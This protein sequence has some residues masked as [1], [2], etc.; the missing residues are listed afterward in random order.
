MKVFRVIR[1]LIYSALRSLLSSWKLNA[2][3]IVT[4]AMTFTILGG[5]YLLFS[6]LKRWIVGGEE[7]V[8]VSV[9][10]R[11]EGDAKGRAVVEKDFCKKDFV[12]E[13]EFRSVEA[14][15]ARFVHDNPELEEAVAALDEN[16]FPASMEIAIASSFRNNMALNSFSAALTKVEGVEAVDDG[17]EWTTRWIKLL[18]ALDGVA[19]LLG[20]ALAFATIFIVAN[21]IRLIVYSR[22]DEI[23]I[24]SLVGATD[25][26][27]RTPFFL[28]GLF[29]GLLA[30]IFALLTLRVSMAVA[31]V[32]FADTWG[33]LFPS[34]IQFL[35]LSSQVGLLLLGAVV[36]VMGSIFAV[37]RYLRT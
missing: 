24:L 10:F 19:L 13:C 33:V 4:L 28:E 9:Y 3:A 29:D 6:N 5:G 30:A 11:T 1:Y 8:H 15:R 17:G 27:I 20:G 12:R 14:A 16:P 21:T 25:G 7:G 23:E 32:Y 31:Q 34:S 35:S 2:V 36:G 18:T 37:G 26:M 22:R